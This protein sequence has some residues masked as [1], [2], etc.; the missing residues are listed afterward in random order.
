MDLSKYVKSYF[1]IFIWIVI[2]LPIVPVVL[3][4]L[5]TEKNIFIFFKPKKTTAEPE[6]GCSK[7]GLKEYIQNDD[8]KAIMNLKEYIII[9][10]QCLNYD[11]NS[12]TGLTIVVVVTI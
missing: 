4:I 3:V 6:K 12:P 10:V 2:C 7:R 5:F 8:T 9:H 11:N 1:I